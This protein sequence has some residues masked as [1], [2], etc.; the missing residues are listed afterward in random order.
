MARWASALFIVAF[1]IALS[2]PARAQPRAPL[3]DSEVRA[4]LEFI[5]GALERDGPAARLWH[6]GWLWGYAG[7]T[8]GEGGVALAAKPSSGLRLGS[9]VGSVKSGIGF[10]SM[11]FS[12]STAS[13]AD[14][15]LHAEPEQTPE[16]RRA[17]L[18]LAE[19]LL[20]KSASEQRFR[21]WF[22]PLGAAAVNLAGTYVLWLG[23]KSYSQGWISL[24]SGM[25]VAELQYFTAPSG[26]MEA[27]DAYRAGRYAPPA[28]R[29]SFTVVPFGRGLS[30]VGAF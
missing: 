27:W 19:H 15:E 28:P 16:E 21:T 3:S 26:S 22:L 23:Y 13:S 10:L 12:P 2:R 1:M 7:L 8:V 24:A 14:A 6:R 25:A 11:L 17:K 5:E 18:Q 20:K 9:A 4:R 29:V 30:V